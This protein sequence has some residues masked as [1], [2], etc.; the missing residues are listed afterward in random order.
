MKEK[1]EQ[2]EQ[3]KRREEKKSL[4]TARKEAAAAKKA[5]KAAKKA[6]E[7]EKK[8]EGQG[9]RV[10]DWWSWTLSQ[11]RQKVLEENKVLIMKHVKFYLFIKSQFGRS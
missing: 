6:S 4:A 9:K 5:D 10:A 11:Q 2:N 7:D 1:E 8:A 3:K